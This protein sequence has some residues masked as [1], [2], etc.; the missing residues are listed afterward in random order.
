MATV[1]KR[2]DTWTAIYSDHNGKQKW[3]KG[4]TD[5]GE[6]L[7]LAQRLEDEQRKIRLG[8]IDPQAD[9]RRIERSKP[10]AD[11]LAAFR[12]HMESKVRHAK[13]VAYTVRDCQLCIDFTGI[14]TVA[15]L[16][17]GDVDR[18]RVELLTVGMKHPQTKLVE[19]DSRKTSNRRIA[20]VRAF[21]RYCHRIGA[22]DRV[23]LDG[24]QMLDTRGHETRKR[25]A[26]KSDEVARLIEKT[27][28]ENRKEIYR[29]ALLTGFRRSEI[30]S[31][32]PTNFDFAKR[33]ITVIASDA[34]YKGQ[35]QSIPMHSAL[36]SPLKHLCKGRKGTD[37]IFAVPRNQDIVRILHADCKAA[38]IDTT[39]VDFHGLRHSYISHLADQNIRP[40][41]LMKLA[42]HRDIKTTIQY[43]IH[44]KH[45]D[46]RDAI[47]LL[48]A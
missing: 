10:V 30:A 24:Y 11:H 21:L 29:F 18:W 40:E 38:D 23:V 4:Y 44:W 46:E 3:V 6:T 37:T 47:E 32:K 9:A 19:K 48:T 41:I 42:R 12:A 1:T 16:S 26:L 15:Q 28:D 25:R 5:K 35:H 20:S 45:E 36:I 43:Y 8:D 27:T 33:T 17:L 13:H 7:R 22:I 39:D 34:K 2:G 14:K 31:M